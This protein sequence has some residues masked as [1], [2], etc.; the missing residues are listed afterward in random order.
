METMLVHS[1][2]RRDNK[3]NN[4]PE[5]VPIGLLNEQQ[6]QSNHSQSLKRLN[7]RGGLGVLE[8]LANYNKGPVKGG[9]TSQSDVDELN[10]LIQ[11][12]IL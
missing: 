12:F 8:I 3:L 10:L 1:E 9:E 4:V 5:K 11:K 2:D 7:E 6:A